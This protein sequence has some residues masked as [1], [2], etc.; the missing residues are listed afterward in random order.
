[1]DWVFDRGFLL[2][3]ALFTFLLVNNTSINTSKPKKLKLSR[4]NSY[5]LGRISPI[6]PS[7]SSSF[8]M[9]AEAQDPTLHLPRIL[10]L[11]GGGVNARVFEMQCRTLIKQLRAEFRLCFADAPFIC[12]PGPGIFPVYK[13]YGPFRRWLRWLPEHAELDAE[14]TVKRIDTHLKQAMD[15]DDAKGAT[16]EW[17]GLLGFSQGAKLAASML[18]TQQKRAEILGAANA[19]SNYRFAVLLAGRA[20]LVSLDPDII[21]SSAVADASQSTQG[22]TDFPAEGEAEKQEHVLRL[23]TIHVHG[24]RDQGLHLHQQLLEQYCEEG[25]A[26][27]IE[28]D[29]DHR[30]PFKNSD[31]AAIKEQILDL[32]RETGVIKEP[33]MT[34]R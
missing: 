25:S 13:D 19:G 29:G 3:L 33:W 23:P 17:V 27:L 11:H 10:C 31:V 28:W 14:T 9:I 2:Q 20:P 7:S 12:N 34:R 24:R 8:T 32:A 15:E 22:F 16:G 18:F 6:V 4:R 21:M 26:R 30:V 1:M 5:F